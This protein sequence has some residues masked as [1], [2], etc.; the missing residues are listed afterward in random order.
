[1]GHREWDSF[2]LQRVGL[3]T[4]HK[5]WNKFLLFQSMSLLD[6]WKMRWAVSLK[7]NITS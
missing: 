1:M 3:A 4:F 7:P 6:A 2:I 5:Y